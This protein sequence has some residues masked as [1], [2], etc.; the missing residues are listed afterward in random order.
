MKAATNCYSYN[1]T[2]Y[3][4]TSPAT[5]CFP[6]IKSPLSRPAALLRH[7]CIS[8]SLNSRP[9]PIHFPSIRNHYL[10]R[11]LPPSGPF[12]I[13]MDTLKKLFSDQ[14]GHNFRP[15]FTLILFYANP[16]FVQLSPK[17]SHTQWNM[18]TLVLHNLARFT[19]Q[20]Q[21]KS[22]QIK[23]HPPRKSTSTSCFLS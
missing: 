6:K 3:T 5:S 12:C 22:S 14:T 11:F 13:I 2:A 10:P 8:I 23:G 18:T 9:S 19:F 4:S 1:Q 7:H 21:D 17:I 16:P 15:T 20:T